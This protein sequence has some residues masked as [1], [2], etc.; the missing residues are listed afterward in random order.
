MGTKYRPRCTWTAEEK[1]AWVADWEK[2]GQTLSEFARQN[3]LP[4]PTLSLWVRQLR[5]PSSGTSEA[6][7]L[8]E[9][10]A[11]AAEPVVH[12]EPVR[13]A[14][15]ANV[16]ARLRLADGTAIEVLDAAVLVPLIRS[17]R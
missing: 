11:P 12:A 14:T 8:V 16:I 2:S 13:P 5:G 9:I 17:L 10:T 1:E 7:P 4:S 15:A 6:G 3:D